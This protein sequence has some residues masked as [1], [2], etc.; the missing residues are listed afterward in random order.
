MLSD[1]ICVPN[2][3]PQGTPLSS[4]LF[5]VYINNIKKY[6]N[7][8]K[9]KLFAD[10]TLIWRA[11]DTTTEAME[12]VQGDLDSLSCYMKMMRLKL[13]INKTKFMVL[14]AKTD[15]PDLSL[16]IDNMTIERVSYIKYLGV[17][18]DDK[19]NFKMHCEY[20]EKKISKKISFLNRIRKKIDKN[21][22]ILLFNSII[23]PHYDFC[24][25]ILFMLNEGELNRLQVL[26]NRALRVILKARRDTSVSLMLHQ[27]DIMSVRQRIN[28]N[29]LIYI[30]KAS[31]SLLPRYITSQLNTVSNIQPYQLRRNGMFRPPNITS[32]LGQNSIMYRGIILFNEMISDGVNVNN[33]IEIFKI[34]LKAYVKNKYL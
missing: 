11:A 30:Y 3:I 20:I 27:T 33:A 29:V 5:L 31:K 16:R 10:D 15:N 8:C 4:L 18:I 28:Y 34:D 24:S 2:G 9:L 32:R 25:S 22:A 23:L 6:I 7:F 1:P 12:M 26:Q 13:N 17:M 14:G 19:L 21:T